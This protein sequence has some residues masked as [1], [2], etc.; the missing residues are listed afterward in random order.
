MKE[1]D[2][3]PE[4]EAESHSPKFLRKALSKSVTM[5]KGKGMKGADAKAV[6]RFGGK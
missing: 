6:K 4:M 2:E 1:Q 3:S 5:K